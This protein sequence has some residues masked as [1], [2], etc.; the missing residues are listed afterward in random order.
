MD[1]T[2]RGNYDSGEDF[3]LEYGE[4]RFTFNERDFSERVEQAARKHVWI[5][6]LPWAEFESDN[7]RVFDPTW[8]DLPPAELAREA[9]AMAKQR[10]SARC[11]PSCHGSTARMPRAAAMA[12]SL[13][14]IAMP[15]FW[16]GP[17]LAIIFAVYLGWLPSSGAGT[18]RGIQYVNHS[19]PRAPNASVCIAS[20][21]SS[22]SVSA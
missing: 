16:L 21:R 20:K 11:A 22:G 13:A 12:V 1:T 17:L 2:R 8:S 6:Q 3:V 15:N 14:G 4:L 19:S 10:M 5:H 9:Q 18:P 7:L